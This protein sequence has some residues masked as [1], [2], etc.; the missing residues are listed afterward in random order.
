M[1]QIYVYERTATETDAATGDTLTF[2]T[3]GAKTIQRPKNIAKSYL[4]VALDSSVDLKGGTLK[5]E[6]GDQHGRFWLEDTLTA[7]GQS[8][9]RFC[10]GWYKVRLT[11]AGASGAVNFA[12]VFQAANEGDHLNVTV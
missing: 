5:I 1:G 6:V 9:R 2:T 12:P 11:L 10:P 4:F 7:A 8:M 3:N